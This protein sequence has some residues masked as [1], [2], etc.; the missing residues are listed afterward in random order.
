MYINSSRLGIDQPWKLAHTLLL[1][2]TETI[3]LLISSNHSSFVIIKSFAHKI[4]N[5]QRT[6]TFICK[7]NRLGYCQPLNICLKVVTG[8]IDCKLCPTWGSSIIL[9]AFI[10]IKCLCFV[11]QQTISQANKLDKSAKLLQVLK[12]GRLF[13]LFTQK[14]SVDGNSFFLYYFFW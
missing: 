7:L 9:V 12:S 11:R 14:V 2:L 4:A 1:K 8:N 3:S 5:F 10:L 13:P 6:C